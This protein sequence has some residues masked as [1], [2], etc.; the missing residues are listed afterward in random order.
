MNIATKNL[1]VLSI[2]E[3]TEMEVLHGKLGKLKK[4]SQADK[5]AIETQVIIDKGGAR[6]V[7]G[8]FNFCESK[9]GISSHRLLEISD[10]EV[11]LLFFEAKRCLEINKSKSKKVI[12]FFTIPTGILSVASLLLTIPFGLGFI[13]SCLSFLILSIASINYCTEKL[14]SHVECVSEFERLKGLGYWKDNPDEKLLKLLKS[15]AETTKGGGR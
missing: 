10:Q 8:F 3:P 9:Y 1:P 2:T 4:L 11:L 15:A 12:K 5:N 14:D 7:S 6:L 13:L